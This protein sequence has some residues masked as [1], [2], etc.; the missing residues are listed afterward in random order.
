MNEN[1]YYIGQPVHVEVDHNE[2]EQPYVTGTFVG[3]GSVTN[4]PNRGW[5]VPNV[6]YAVAL[7]ELDYEYQGHTGSVPSVPVEIMV[8]ELCNLSPAPWY[9]NVY[10]ID[11]RYGGPEEGGWWFDSG[12]LVDSTE[13]ASKQDANRLSEAKQT[14]Y[15]N[16]GSSVYR[17][18]DY[19]VRIE[20]HPGEN[21]PTNRPHYE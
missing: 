18:G 12:T 7:V 11:R 8:A 6:T 9:V 13:T 14:E 1:N 10:E 17:G 4:P 3:F 15:P 20:N 5:R 16:N 2:D 21:Y 19:T